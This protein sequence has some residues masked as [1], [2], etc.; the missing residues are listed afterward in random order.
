MARLISLRWM[1]HAFGQGLLEHTPR[2]ATR[3]EV[4]LGQRARQTAVALVVGLHLG[5]GAHRLVHVP[6]PEEVVG[7]GKKAAG[8]RVLYHGR[9]PAGQI[10]GSAVAD[11]TGRQFNVGGLG[12]TELTPRLLDVGAVLLGRR[13]HVPSIP[14]PPAERLQARAPLLEE[15]PEGD[16]LL[17]GDRGESRQVRVLQEPNQLVVAQVPAAELSR[18]TPPM[19]NSSIGRAGGRPG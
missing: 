18:P 16:R 19:G 14:E 5:Q 1:A 17:E 7:I 3:V 4:F 6:E 11:P 13:A 9:L 12:T 8:T 2:D 15:A 10:A